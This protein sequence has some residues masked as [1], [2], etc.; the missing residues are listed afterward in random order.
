MDRNREGTDHGEA[1]SWNHLPAFIYTFPFLITTGPLYSV[2]V[3]PEDVPGVRE[4][5]WAPLTRHFAE[6]SFM[7]DVVS[8][9]HL[10]AYLGERIMPAL[11]ETHEVLTRNVN[12]FN[13]EF[14]QQKYGKSSDPLFAAWLKK[15]TSEDTDG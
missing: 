8:F 12:L 13:P 10:E 1:D 9:P 7:M 3:V 15:F 4:V 5:P 6:T 11:K 14:L 2:D